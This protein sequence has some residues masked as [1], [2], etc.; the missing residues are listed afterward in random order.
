MKLFLIKIKDGLPVQYDEY[1]G[2]VVRAKNLADI[3]NRIV[4]T[5]FGDGRKQLLE[6]AY[7]GFDK[8]NDEPKKFYELTAQDYKLNFEKVIV[9]E[10]G[11]AKGELVGEDFD[12][13]LFDFNAA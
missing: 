12:I 11:V 4:P 13:V 2:Y 6:L 3:L 7:S 1:R 8:I 10:I 5:C 9:E